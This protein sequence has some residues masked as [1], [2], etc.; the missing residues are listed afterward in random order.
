MTI[1]TRNEVLVTCNNAPLM[2]LLRH[3]AKDHAP[4]LD[5]CLENLGIVGTRL[6]EPKP[7]KLNVST[8]LEDA[9]VGTIVDT[10]DGP[11]MKVWRDKWLWIADDGGYSQT[12]LKYTESDRSM[13]RK[14]TA[15]VLWTP[16]VQE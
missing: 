2:E 10:K 8:D 13:S 4:D 9:P 5:Y 1:A 14:Y 3:L 12:H 11:H 16:E 6:E 15:T 7:R